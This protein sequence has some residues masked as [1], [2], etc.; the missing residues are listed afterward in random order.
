MPVHTSRAHLQIIQETCLSTQE[1][2]T[3]E[4]E[5]WEENQ[6]TTAVCGM[7]N[8]F[9]LHLFCRLTNATLEQQQSGEMGVVTKEAFLAFWRVLG[10]SRICT[11]WL[12]A[13]GRSRLE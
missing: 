3:F 10:S 6:M 13:G 5:A 4:Q 2:K 9:T 8:F 12:P 1:R 7:P 11:H